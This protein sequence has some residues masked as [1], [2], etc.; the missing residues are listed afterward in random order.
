MNL[1]KYNAPT[2][3]VVIMM[4]VEVMLRREA[5]QSPARRPNLEENG[6]TRR[7]EQKEPTIISDEMSCCTVGCKVLEM[8]IVVRNWMAYIDIP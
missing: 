1:A 5:A 4:R 6:P 3:V 2:W 8:D 7:A